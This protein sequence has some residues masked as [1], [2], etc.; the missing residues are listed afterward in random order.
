VI[1]G[2][3]TSTEST[4]T[5]IHIRVNGISFLAKSTAESILIHAIRTLVMGGSETGT[6]FRVEMVGGTA[7]SIRLAEGLSETLVYSVLS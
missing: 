4:D 6:V 3:D 1:F 2:S 7:G 5:A